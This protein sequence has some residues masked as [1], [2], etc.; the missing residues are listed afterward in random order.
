MGLI[1]YANDDLGTFDKDAFQFLDIAISLLTC[2]LYCVIMEASIGTTI[3][4]LITGA[5]VISVDGSKP[6]LSQIIGRSF[7]R[8]IPFEPFSFLGGTNS[9]W[10]DTMSNTRVILKSE[11]KAVRNNVHLLD[12]WE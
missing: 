11:M 3:G 4:K 2:V 1:L 5:V 12:D 9:G 7:A 8:L 6:S 10:H